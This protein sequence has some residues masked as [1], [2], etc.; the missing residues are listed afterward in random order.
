MKRLLKAFYGNKY[1]IFVLLLTFVAVLPLIHSGL[2]PTHDGE[3]HI[4]RFFEFE[5]AIQHGD[6]Y[7][8]WAMDLNNGYGLPLFNYVYP[9]PNYIAVIFHSFGFSFISAFKLNLILATLLGS[10]FFYYWLRDYWGNIGGLVAA[11]SYSYAP[12]RFVDM[13]VRGS[14]GE[15]WV[16]AFIP[17]FLWS[18]SRSIKN[19]SSNYAIISGIFF[20]AIIFSHNILAMMFF[21]FSLS[22]GLLLVIQSNNWKRSI[23]Y[24]IYSFGVAVS[25]SAIFWFPA[26]I[27][28]SYVRGL[29]IYS[30]RDN[31]PELY[32]LLIPSWGT[33]FSGGYIGNQMSFQIGIMPLIGVLILVF[34]GFLFRRLKNNWVI[35]LFFTFWFAIIVFFM[36][37][38]SVFL[39]EA[40]PLLHYFQFPWRFL[41]LTMVCTSFINGSII[42]FLPEKIRY[43]SAGIIICLTIFTTLNYTKPAYYHNRTDSYYL[44]RSNFIDGTNSPGDLFNTRWMGKVAK[45]NH[46][47]RFLGGDGRITVIDERNSRRIYNVD[48]FSGGEVVASLAYFPGWTVFQDGVNKASSVTKEG[49]LTFKVDKGKHVIEVVFLDTIVR[50]IAKTWSIT[51][52]IVLF[53][54]LYRK[55]IKRKLK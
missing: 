20:A 13:Y 3:Y 52:A 28:T 16:L 11:V 26:L 17:A 23:K 29:E 19:K 46:D 8:R 44:S 22:Y 5:K 48:S 18:I 51:I 21:I 1:I 43:L 9:F 33:G 36:L 30:V 31:F 55:H 27:E 53:I 10:L 24:I 40:V 39:W 50:Q 49:L 45:T 42:L 15:V 2:P 47:I 7:P 12:Y 54:L 4:I 35:V 25:L 34:Y 32:Q 37:R 14:V 38:S 41:S 6:L